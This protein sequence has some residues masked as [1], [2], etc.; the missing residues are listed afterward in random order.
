MRKQRFE[1]ET[2][3]ACSLINAERPT[4][5]LQRSYTS[6]KTF[7]KL[8]RTIYVITPF[9]SLGVLTFAAQ[10]P[11][12]KKSTHYTIISAP[13]AGGFWIERVAVACL[14]SCA[15]MYTCSGMH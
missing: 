8:F 6:Y 2:S 9:Y 10:G 14:C 12:D 11:N 13:C 4:N 15:H 5:M 3:S 1:T 7:E